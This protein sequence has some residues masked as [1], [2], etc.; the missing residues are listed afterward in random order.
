MFEGAIILVIG[1]VMGFVSGLFWYE[2]T[3]KI[4]IEEDTIEPVK[5][6]YILYRNKDGLLTRHKNSNKKDGEK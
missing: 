6:P 1:I 2:R 5:D 3:D 4:I